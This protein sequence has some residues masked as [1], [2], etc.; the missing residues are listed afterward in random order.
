[1]IFRTA[2]VDELGDIVEWCDKLT[3]EEIE[4][5]LDEHVEWSRKAIQVG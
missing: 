5:M 2:I 4:E 1:M 3:E